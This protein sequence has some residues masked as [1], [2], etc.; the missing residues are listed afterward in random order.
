MDIHT[1]LKFFCPNFFFWKKLRNTLNPKRTDWRTQTSSEVP[2]VA[3]AKNLASC[4]ELG[5]SQPQLVLTFIAISQH[6]YIVALL[7]LYIITLINCYFCL[8]PLQL[9]NPTQLQMVGEGLDFVFPQKKEGITLTLLL[10]EGMTL[11]VWTMLAVLWVSGEWL[12]IVWRVSGRCLTGVLQVSGRCLKGVWKVP[13]GYLKGV[14]WVSM[15]C[16][17]Y[18]LVISQG[19]SRIEIS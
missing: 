19:R 7:H 6:V 9:A 2:S 15:G 3:L 4:P 17:N 10:A 12:E 13:G 16:P 5:S 11:H 8:T 18:Y 1:Y 14:W